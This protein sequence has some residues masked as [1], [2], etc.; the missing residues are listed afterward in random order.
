MTTP[1]LFL[2]FGLV[3]C[4]LAVSSIVGAFAAGRAPRVAAIVLLIG[5]GLIFLALDQRSY[6]LNE[7]PDVFFRVVTHFLPI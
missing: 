5:G 7:I 2:V 1:D 3:I 4:A 6:T